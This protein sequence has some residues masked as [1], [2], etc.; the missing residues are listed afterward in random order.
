MQTQNRRQS[1]LGLL[2][3]IISLGAIFFFIQPAAIWEALQTA[4]YGQL[5][6]TAVGTTLFLIFRAV[7]WRFMLN[8]DPSW[9]DVYHIQ[10]IGYLVTNVLPLRLGDITRA[11]LIGSVPPVTLARGLSTVV[12]ERV[13]DMLFVITLLPF[14]LAEVAV[15]PDWMQTGARVSGFLAIGA[16]V[17]LIFAANQRPLAARV[18]TAVLER[19]PPLDTVAWVRRLDD[20]LAGLDSLTR[21]RE[22]LLLILLTV[23]AWAPILLTYYT[24]LRAVHIT[25]TWPMVA[26]VFCAAAFSV[27]LP[28]SPGQVGVFHAGVFAAL[29]ILEQPEAASASFG[30]LYHA[31]NLLSMIVW[32]LIGVYATGATFNKV[33]A[34]T[35][36]FVQRRR[37]S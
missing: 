4:D 9:R 29:Q 8:N 25:P 31:I 11:V 28:S 7:R 14:S 32:G 12:V 13:F 37:S 34:S 10:N 22:G 3:T 20:L 5:L 18:A 35:R 19:I 17:V 1:W 33:V 26:F 21:L 36:E 16:I 23:L 15:L 24:T 27:A 6:L 30:F 2:V